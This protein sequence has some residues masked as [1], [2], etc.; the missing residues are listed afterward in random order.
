MSCLLILRV[1]LDLRDLFKLQKGILINYVKLNC[2]FGLNPTDALDNIAYARAYNTDHQMTL[3]QQASAMMSEARF[4]LLIVDSATALFRTDFTGRGQLADRQQLLAKY[5]RQ[6]Q[7]LADEFGV[8]VVI[9]NQVVANP[10]GSATFAGAANQVKPIGGNII[11]HAST[12]RL[13][14]RKGR[15]TT[16]ICK[17]VGL[18]GY[19]FVII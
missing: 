12:T 10:D 18:S 5:L 2:R 1:L 7:R 9:T 3:L 14:L 16:R 15:G 19:I 17:V 4:A 11:A 6:L 13:S 8:A